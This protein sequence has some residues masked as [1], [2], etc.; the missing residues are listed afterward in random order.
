MNAIVVTS[1]GTDF[2]VAEL[3]VPVPGAGQIQVRV[4]AAS[5]NPGDVVIP[6]GDYSVPLDFPYVPGND[7][8]GT[9]SAVGDGV[10]AYASG[11]LVFGHGVPRALRA[12]GGSSFTTGTLAEYAV[13]EADTPF[14][15]RRPAGMDVEMAA[16]LPTVGLTANALMATVQ[17]VRGERV[18]VIGAT[19]GVGMT[20]L[21]LLRDAGAQVIATATE[22]DSDVVRERGAGETVPY[23]EY[24]D[25]VDTVLNLVIP[26]DR[27][28]DAGKALRPGGR[29]FTITFPPPQPS[30]LGRDDVRFELVLDMEGRLGGMAEVA[31][32][33]THIGR[34]YDGLD[35]GVRAL[36]DFTGRHT[37]GKLVVRI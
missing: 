35:Q 26:S 3:P 17:P 7:F 4:A 23:G 16:A 1:Y 2:S 24:P 32:L 29:L 30:L 10:S 14:L 25:D 19:G 9:V 31:G 20:V 18:L 6:R 33:T 13:F 34:R 27:L 22:S 37:T 36:A 15:A 21:P 11:D 28:A 8:A 5:I 12:M